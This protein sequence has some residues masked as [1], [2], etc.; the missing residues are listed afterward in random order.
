LLSRLQE[1]E[2]FAARSFDGSNGLLNL[3]E[4]ECICDSE[5]LGVALSQADGRRDILPLFRGRDFKKPPKENNS[6][7][8][9]LLVCHVQ[10]GHSN[11]TSVEGTVGKNR[12]IIRQERKQIT[13]QRA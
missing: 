1:H 7:D 12:G 10:T 6:S 8:R 2:P 3:I 13:H 11:W 4:A 9:K 5:Q